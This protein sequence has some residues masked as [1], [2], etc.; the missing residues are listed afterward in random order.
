[1]KVSHTIPYSLFCF[2]ILFIILQII[3]IAKSSLKCEPD[4]KSKGDDFPKINN[5]P[6]NNEYLYGYEFAHKIGE[7]Y[8][9]HW[10]GVYW[11]NESFCYDAFDSF[12]N[13][14]SSTVLKDYE[15]SEFDVVSNLND[16][17][18]KESYILIEYEQSN[19]INF[20]KN[21]CVTKLHNISNISDYNN[22][23]YELFIKMDNTFQE[24]F[25]NKPHYFYFTIENPSNET[26]IFS[27][28]IRNYKSY[29]K[30]YSDVIEEW[31]PNMSQC[32]EE[33]EITERKEDTIDMKTDI[34]TD[35]ITN[36]KTDI[37]TDIITDIKSNM[38]TD[39]KSDMKTDIMTD[40]IQEIWSP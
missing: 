35:I 2:F 20:H 8:Y 21:V 40:I 17:Q 31:G 29:I 7:E 23:V 28:K 24:D 14:S 3:P 1:M 11:D 4:F 36:M 33:T 30:A 25:L 15:I 12:F 13:S 10:K 34:K 27:F 22:D 6:E 37:E 5:P 32:I 19:L 26:V 39:I 16:I 38:I 9:D 18:N